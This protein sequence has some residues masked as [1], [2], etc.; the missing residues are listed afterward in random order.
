M[1]KKISHGLPLLL[2]GFLGPLP[3][4]ADPPFRDVVFEVPLNLTDLPAIISKVA[5]DCEVKIANVYPTNQGSYLVRT[6]TTELNV[7]GGAVSQTAQVLVTLPSIVRHLSSSV[8]PGTYTCT[9]RAFLE[10]GLGWNSFVHPPTYSTNLPASVLELTTANSNVF[11]SQSQ[12]NFIG[13]IQW[14]ASP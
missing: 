10:E 14:P 5:V 9:L 1:T 11:S 8:P 4:L 7:V 2:A 13:S 6:G 3:S 12:R